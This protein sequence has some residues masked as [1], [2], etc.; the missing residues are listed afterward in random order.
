MSLHWHGLGHIIALSCLCFLAPTMSTAPRRQIS[1]GRLAT[2]WKPCGYHSPKVSQGDQCDCHRR[3]RV[4]MELGILTM[5]RTLRGHSFNRAVQIC[6]SLR[7]MTR[8]SSSALRTELMLTVLICN[9]EDR[10]KVWKTEA[11]DRIYL[12]L[13]LRSN[14]INGLTRAN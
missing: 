9:G 3:R 12:V 13:S 4:E 5:L 1:S 2:P 14:S 10:S 11:V 6:C 8:Y 7:K